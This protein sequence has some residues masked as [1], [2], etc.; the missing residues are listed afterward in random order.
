[1][2]LSSPR[3]RSFF[4]PQVVNGHSH[5]FLREHL[6]CERQIPFRR[7]PCPTGELAP[8]FVREAQM[9]S[10]SMQSLVHMCSCVCDT[11]RLS[12]ACT[13]SLLVSVKYIIERPINLTVLFPE[14]STLQCAVSMYYLLASFRS[15]F[16][17]ISTQKART[18]VIPFLCRSLG[19]E[20]SDCC[21]WIPPC[22][23]LDTGLR[24]KPLMPGL[25]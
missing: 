12:A 21:P 4:C 19:L 14:H 25:L 23:C 11:H 10:W 1:M 20:R 16:S 2:V 15:Y 3:G 8:L 9:G 7:F 22:P 13:S 5:T 18:I 6:C 24:G 17:L